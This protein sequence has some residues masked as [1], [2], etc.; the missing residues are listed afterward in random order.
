LAVAPNF[1]D[2][3]ADEDELAVIMTPSNPTGWEQII[4]E[5]RRWVNCKK[6]TD[7]STCRPFL[8]LIFGLPLVDD[9]FE[10]IQRS[11]VVGDWRGAFR[12]RWQMRR[13][14]INFLWAHQASTQNHWCNINISPYFLSSISRRC[15]RQAAGVRSGGGSSGRRCHNGGEAGATRGESMSCAY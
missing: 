7:K 2:P 11:D 5:K 1:G 3:V 6:F 10:G 13:W 15:I 9:V 8:T 14:E 12:S 4:L